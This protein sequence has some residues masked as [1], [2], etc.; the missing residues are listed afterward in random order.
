[1]GSVYP[2]KGLM[3][4]GCE[5]PLYLLR[6]ES[7]ETQ[8]KTLSGTCGQSQLYRSLE[9]VGFAGLQSDLSLV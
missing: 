4:C 1:M 7:T 6:A 5:W 2:K 3:T 8:Q 9:D